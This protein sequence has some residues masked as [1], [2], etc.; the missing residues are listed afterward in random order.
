MG[1]IR[2]EVENGYA[3][4]SC[5]CCESEA[6]T[7]QETE[8]SRLLA[9]LPTPN[10][11]LDWEPW[12][13]SFGGNRKSRSFEWFVCPRCNYDWIEATWELVGREGRIEHLTFALLSEEPFTILLRIETDPFTDEEEVV[14]ERHLRGRILESYP[15]WYAGLVDQRRSYT[16]E[17]CDI[18][19]R[20]SG[21]ARPSIDRRYDSEGTSS[22][23]GDLSESKDGSG[24]RLV[25]AD[26]PS[27]PSRRDPS[28]TGSLDPVSSRQMSGE[29][30][31]R[32][33]R[34]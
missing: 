31:K 13:V 29:A 27:E 4:V 5:R 14:E 7:I 21:D 2:P 15:I 26:P 34:Q 11:R 10:S 32:R 3:P 22:I 18:P 1:T 20:L 28:A 25:P 24:R 9:I 8:S 12:I 17:F 6:V 33:L 16:R 19:S 23:S 30:K